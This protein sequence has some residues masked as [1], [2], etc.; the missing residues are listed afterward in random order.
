MPSLKLAAWMV[1]ISA[2]T[3]FGV[4]HYEQRKG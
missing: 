2:A 4:K 3:V 1:V